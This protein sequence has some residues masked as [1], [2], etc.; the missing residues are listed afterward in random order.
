MS[1]HQT[2]AKDMTNSEESAQFQAA[3]TV[4]QNFYKDLDSATDQESVEIAFNRHVDTAYHWRGM[5]PFYEID[6][7]EEVAKR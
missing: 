1:P 2:S 3:K 4:V 7:A 6:S 5:H